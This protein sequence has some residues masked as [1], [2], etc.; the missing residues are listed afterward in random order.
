VYTAVLTTMFSTSLTVIDGFPRAIER[1]LRVAFSDAPGEVAH[2][3]TQTEQPY[4][5]TGRPYWSAMLVLALGTVVVLSVFPGSL[6]AMVDF[7][8]IV[9]F[10]TAPLLGYL[11]LRAVT[12]AEVPSA[13]R[14]GPRLVALSWISLL[15]LGAFAVV[16]LVARV[17]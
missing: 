1:A 11:N 4:G 8:T 13:E 6:T 10:M 5:G 2:A 12:S 14:P 15:V 16:Y 7:A 9:S 3:G 17:A